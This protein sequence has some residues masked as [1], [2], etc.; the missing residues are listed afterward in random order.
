MSN[1]FDIAKKFLQKNL[2]NPCV[3]S[4]NGL[5]TRLYIVYY[6]NLGHKQSNKVYMSDKIQDNL[7][8]SQETVSNQDDGKVIM[9]PNI[10]E[11]IPLPKNATEALPNMT[12]E[13]ELLVRAETIKELSD[14]TGEHIE[15][16]ADNVHDAEELAKGM[17]EDKNLR[18][19]F[20]TYPNE[21][22]AFL[23]GLVSQ[24]NHMIVKDLSELKLYVVNNLVRAVET[25]DNT[26]EKIAGLRAIGEIDGVDAFK[27]K[28]EVTHKVETMEEVEK[29]LLDM[30][31]SLKAKAVSGS[32]NPNP[33]KNQVIDAEYTEVKAK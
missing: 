24:T 5:Q 23:A 32:T 21:T 22:I 15:V 9:V 18:P 11:N 10:E 29:E 14:V 30:L 7:Q 19:E 4:K 8:D 33:V 26:K 16:D 17:I 6:A 13:E 1:I 31:S 3:K 12:S 2:Q 28:T 20:A 27:K 25:T